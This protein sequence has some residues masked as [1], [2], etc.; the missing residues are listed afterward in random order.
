MMSWERLSLQKKNGAIS[1]SDNFTPTFVQKKPRRRGWLK[2]VAIFESGFYP[3][4]KR[5]QN[6]QPRKRNTLRVE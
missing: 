2:N 5:N 3:G 4:L 1:N 6:E